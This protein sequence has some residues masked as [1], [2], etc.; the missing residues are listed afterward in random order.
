MQTS[1]PIRNQ[2]KHL[3]PAHGAVWLTARHILYCTNTIR[4]PYLSFVGALPESE[5][6]SAPRIK[7]LYTSSTSPSIADDT[8]HFQQCS[9]AVLITAEI[10]ASAPRSLC[11][12]PRQ[13]LGLFDHFILFGLGGK[14]DAPD[15]ELRQRDGGFGGHRRGGGRRR[16]RGG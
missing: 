11:F 5:I 9:C 1:S 14:R 7:N 16:G 6:I 15:F 10:D 12:L 8:C 13:A 4:E 3:S 2:H